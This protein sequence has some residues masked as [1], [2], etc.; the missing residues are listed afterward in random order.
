MADGQEITPSAAKMIRMEEQR[1]KQL[2][3]DIMEEYISKD[4]TVIECM[5]KYVEE[6]RNQYTKALRCDQHDQ[7]QVLCGRRSHI[8]GESCKKI[9]I[10]I[11]IIH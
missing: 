9:Y 11:I 3:D 7:R 10:I 4:T 6:I 2:L 5:S 8:C 1:A